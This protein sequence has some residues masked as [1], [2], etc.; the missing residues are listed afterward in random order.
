M[1]LRMELGRCAALEN[2]GGLWVCSIYRH[3]PLACHELQRGSPAC[4]EERH[5]KLH[6]V[7]ASDASRGR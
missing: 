7:R 1:Y 5:L 4:L 6:L 3:R 2:R